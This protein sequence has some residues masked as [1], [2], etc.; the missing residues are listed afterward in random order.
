MRHPRLPSPDDLPALT[1]FARGYLHEDVLAEHGTP[2][3]A[4]SAFARDASPDERHQLIA[5]LE[6][7]TTALAESPPNRLKR[8]FTHNLRAAWT[9]ETVDDLRSLIARIRAR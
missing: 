3:A 2:E 1:A 4:A 8:F 5:E 6:R 9:P 7:L